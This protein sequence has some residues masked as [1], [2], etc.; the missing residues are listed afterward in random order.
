[1]NRGLSRKTWL[2]QSTKWR[3]L[4]IPFELADRNGELYLWVYVYD[5]AGALLY[6]TGCHPEQG[7]GF[8]G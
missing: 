7:A 8:D 5:D 1:M 3:P 4:S 2:T 6:E